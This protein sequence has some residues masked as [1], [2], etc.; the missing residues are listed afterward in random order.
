MATV[1]KPHIPIHIANRRAKDT[2]SSA[3]PQQSHKNK[4]MAEFLACVEVE[5]DVSSDEDEEMGQ[6]GGGTQQRRLDRERIT[7]N[8]F[9]HERLFNEQLQEDEDRVTNPGFA[10]MFNVIQKHGAQSRALAEETRVVD[11]ASKSSS[12]SSSSGGGATRRLRRLADSDDDSS[13]DDMAPSFSSRQ[14][15]SQ[16]QQQRKTSTFAMDDEDEQDDSP[17]SSP[18]GIV[19]K[20]RPSTDPRILLPSEEKTTNNHIP[21]FLRP[22]R[23]HFSTEV[24]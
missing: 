7:G 2:T 22:M 23:R 11:R 4:K 13:D 14:P 15:Q 17:T 24:V 8:H 10:S 3:K 12:S 21:L 1:N 16:Q 6:S 18:I 5:G 20:R 9:Q 19:A